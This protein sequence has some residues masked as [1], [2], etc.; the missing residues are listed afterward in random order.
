MSNLIEIK[1]FLAEDGSGHVTQFLHSSG[2]VTEKTYVFD[3]LNKRDQLP[4]R[5]ASII[6]QDGRKQVTV[7][8]EPD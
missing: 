1:W 6:R 3:S 2:G 8:Y 7:S 5:L 4:P